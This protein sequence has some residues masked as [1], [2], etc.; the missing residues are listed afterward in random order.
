MDDFYLPEDL[1]EWVAQRKSE[2]LSRLITLVEADDFSF[3]DHHRFEDHLPLTLARP[4][5]TFDRR[6]DGHQVRTFI[7]SYADPEFFQ[8]IVIGVFFPDQN[9]EE[10]FLPILT[11]VT[12]KEN[13]VREF[14]QGEPSVKPTM[15]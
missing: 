6:D 5:L 3:E 4:D 9:G 15:N 8:Q 10:V 2:L 13:L 12:R 14:C 1:V 11:F 7:R